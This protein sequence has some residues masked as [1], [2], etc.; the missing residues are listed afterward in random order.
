MI[1]KHSPRTG[2]I[3]AAIV[4][5]IAF[6]PLT[7][8]AQPE[9]VVNFY[10]WSDYID[11]TVLDDFSKETGIKVRYDTFDSNDTLEAKLLAGKSGYDVVVPTGYF[12]ARQI[13]AGIFRPLDKSKLPNLANVWPEIAKDLAVYDL[14]NLYAVNYMWGTTGIGYNVKAA[15]QAL[16]DAAIDSW[17]DI[18]GPDKIAKFKDC[19]VYLLDSS[20]D[21]MSAALH[22]LHLDPNS[23][24][25]ADLEQATELLAKIRPFVRKFHSSEYLNAL[26]T[27]EACLVLGFSGDVKQA[28]KRAAEAKAGVEI[29]YAIPKEGAQ[30]WFDNLAIP[31]D[32][33]DV[34]AAHALIDYLLKP[35]VAAKNSN[36]ISYANGNLASRKFI[37]PSILNDRTIYPDAATM[38][39]L[40]TIVA[41]DQKTQRLVNRLWTRI[42]TGI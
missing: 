9:R 24:N 36:F 11:P 5:S 17:D 35:E 29:G 34:D 25:P 12:L 15:R 8:P 23:S 41:H 39:K 32:A 21:V 40:Y 42:K 4:A 10:N 18:F 27:G 14:G 2:G 16:G 7:V 6:T 38:A 28:Q 22:Y 1:S 30:L 20:D 37:D 19:G 13:A 33:P 31:N 3:I 26:A